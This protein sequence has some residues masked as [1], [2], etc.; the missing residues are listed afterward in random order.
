MVLYVEWDVVLVSSLA[1]FVGCAC[2]ASTG[3][4]GSILFAVFTIFAQLVGVSS[5]TSLRVVTL[6]FINN[7]IQT[8]LIVG[9]NA[10]AVF[11]N[12]QNVAVGKST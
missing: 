1:S 10:N 6:G 11:E 7:L 2:L 3:F 12:R 9:S 8:V 4:G 5:L